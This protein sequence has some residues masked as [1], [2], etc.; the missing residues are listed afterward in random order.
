VIKSG[1]TVTEITRQ[2]HLQTTDE[3]RVELLLSVDGIGIPVASAILAV[4]YP[5]DFTVIDYRA[6]ASIKAL[7]PERHKSIVPNPTAFTKGYIRYVAVCKEIAKEER[8]SLRD[9]DRALW[10]YD[11]YEGENGLKKL[12]ASLSANK[13]ER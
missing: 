12:V 5:D 2:M 13:S 1:K 7:R 3:Q 8:L 4:C 11:F 9:V 6:I 10:G